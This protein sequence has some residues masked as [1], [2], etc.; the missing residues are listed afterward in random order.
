[1]SRVYEQEVI[2]KDEGKRRNL[3]MPKG[4][5]QWLV[6]GPALLPLGADS[7]GPVAP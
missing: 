1:M 2:Y 3:H 5:S 4:L 6:M 7:R